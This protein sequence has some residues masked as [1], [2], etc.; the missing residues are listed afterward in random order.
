MTLG[1]CRLVLGDID[2]AYAAA[3]HLTHKMQHKDGH[4]IKDY[5]SIPRSSGY[6][7]YHL[8]SMNRGID[9]DYRVELQIRTKLQ[10]LWSTAVEAASF[11]Y[12]IDY[13]TE[14]ESVLECPSQEQRVRTFFAIVSSLF[15]LEEGTPGVPGH[16]ASKYELVRRL[17]DLRSSDG[18]LQD[19]RSANEGVYTLDAKTNPDG[20]SLYLMRFAT[21]QQFLDIQSFPQEQLEDAIASYGESEACSS[22]E[23]GQSANETLYDNVLLAY[24]QDATQLSLAFPNYSAHIAEFIEHVEPFL[25]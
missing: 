6:R 23:R 11:I 21:D 12:G 9:R 17:R 2:E 3:A 10:H 19:L 4:A 22:L 18:I 1:G 14:R 5:I 24:A 15:A 13:K 8:V 7:S 16:T 20:P 25:H